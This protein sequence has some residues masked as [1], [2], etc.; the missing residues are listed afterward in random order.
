MGNFLAHVAALMVASFFGD[1]EAYFNFFVCHLIELLFGRILASVCEAQPRL[2]VSSF[3]LF[4]FGLFCGFLL[5][6]V[7]FCLDR[8]HLFRAFI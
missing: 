8:F 2:C 7:C 3:F 5:A 1:F 6:P 4:R